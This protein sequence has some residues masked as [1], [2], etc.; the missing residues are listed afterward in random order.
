MPRT[1]AKKSRT[2]ADPASPAPASAVKD[3]RHA[4]DATARPEAG[5]AP[6]FRAKRETAIYRYDSSLSPALD[7]DS[8][9][10]RDTAA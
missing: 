7:W 2:A 3:Y 10:A 5:A 4:Q 1:P 6:R 9:P 8:N